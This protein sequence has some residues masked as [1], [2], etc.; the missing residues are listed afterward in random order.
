MS[1]ASRRLHA[2][3]NL[4]QLKRQAKELKRAVSGGDAQALERALPHLTKGRAPAE[5]SLRDA[6]HVLARE[7]GY[8]GW[9]DLTGWLESESRQL[10][11]RITAGRDGRVTDLRRLLEDL[12]EAH[13][14]LL[15]STLS[16]HLGRA[17]RVAVAYVDVT[18]Y[19]EYVMSVSKPA[20]GWL[21]E[22]DG[23]GAPACLDVGLPIAMRLLGRDEAPDGTRLPDAEVARLEPLARQV[24]EDLRVAFQ[25][26]G[27]VRLRQM[28]FEADAQ[29]MEA[30][31]IKDVV[32]LVGYEVGDPVTPEE[33]WSFVSLAYPVTAVTSLLERLQA[34]TA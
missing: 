4:D 1:A 29:R 19:G 22:A 27:D 31:H 10:W 18:T 15:V 9:D 2:D 28:R 32:Y 34:Q 5:V 7:Y 33:R 3:A 17:V 26:A 20:C 16:R 30:A 12:H 25:P 13:V 8:D 6:Q 23:F 11:Q 21:F 24:L 14:P